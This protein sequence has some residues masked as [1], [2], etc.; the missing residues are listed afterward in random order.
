MAAAP[1]ALAKLIAP[2]Q[3]TGLLV[4]DAPVA[5][6]APPVKWE[7][8]LAPVG[9]EF[10]R[11]QSNFNSGMT[12]PRARLVAP[13]QVVTDL[14]A[15][16]APVAPVAPPAKWEELLASVR[17]DRDVVLRELDRS[18]SNFG[19][20]AL[21]R[22]IPRPQAPTEPSVIPEPNPLPGV[23]DPL[24]SPPPAPEVVPGLVEL[25]VAVPRLRPAV[26]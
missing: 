5:P 9:R 24:P 3:V 7:E 8:L 18:F 17:R 10:E 19:M 12:A 13:P 15:T 25:E 4:T 26:W 2:P 14:L 1:A 23:D 22:G 21:V 16:D 6:V 20:P 11:T